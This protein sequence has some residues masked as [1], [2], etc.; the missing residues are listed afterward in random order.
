MQRYLL[1]DELK[2]MN[3]QPVWCQIPS[4]NPCWGIV[5]VE[6]ECVVLRRFNLLPFKYYGEWKA[7]KTMNI[8]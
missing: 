6:N 2:K 3:G 5:D 1:F 4:D 7:Y 8:R